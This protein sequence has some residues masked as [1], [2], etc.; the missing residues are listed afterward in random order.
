MMPGARRAPISAAGLY[1]VQAAV[2]LALRGLFLFANNLV[3]ITIAGIAAFLL[4]G[5]PPKRWGIPAGV[6]G[7][8]IAILLVFM[9]MITGRIVLGVDWTG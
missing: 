8:W 9:A 7:I 6:L 4:P 1:F 3:C 5:L 2:E